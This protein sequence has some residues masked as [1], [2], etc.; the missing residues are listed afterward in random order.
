MATLET[1]RQ[2]RNAF[3]ILKE[4]LP[5]QNSRYEGRIK[6]VLYIQ[7]FRTF[8]FHVPCL[9][10][11]LENVFPPKQGSKPG[12][13]KKYETGKRD[14]PRREERVIPG[15]GAA[16]HQAWRM[17]V[18]VREGQRLQEGV[19]IRLSAP[20]GQGGGTAF[21]PPADES[22]VTFAAKDPGN[23]CVGEPAPTWPHSFSP[24]L[25]SSP[26][27][28]NLFPREGLGTGSYSWWLIHFHRLIHLL[29]KNH[30]S[31]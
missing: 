16:V 3:L 21:C 10:K 8:S 17:T 23:S 11:L 14:S 13:R 25:F 4:F 20:L 22:R 9:W 7:R 19:C 12:K 5:T 31:I 26:A 28:D 1:G 15:G 18:Q 6:T 30:P 24:P 27:V 29:S 2:W